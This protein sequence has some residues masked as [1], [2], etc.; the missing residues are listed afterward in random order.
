[1]SNSGSSLHV[2]IAG[3]SGLI[4][5]AL[6]PALER[7]GHRLTRLVR[8]EPRPDRD[9]LGWNPETG[10]IAA[11]AL[12]DADAV[13][14]FGGVNIASGR[15]TAKLKAAIRDSRLGSTQ[16]L[17]ETLARLT[18]PPR[19]FICASAT[20]YY[21][22]RVDEILA[23]DSPPGEGLLATLC[24]D[25]EAATSP[26]RQ[27][28]IRVVN[29]RTGVVLTPRGGALA[30]MLPAFKAGLGGVLGSGKQYVS[31]ISLH[32]LTRV[33]EFALAN[34]SITG[35]INAVAPNPV[36]NRELT[37]TLGRVLKRPTWFRMPAL[38]VRIAFGE[39]GQALLLEGHRLRPLRLEQ[40]GF[41][42]DHPTLEDALRHELE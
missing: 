30:K 9:E 37:R 41:E 3:A 10:E 31:W 36:T 20:G 8:R 15:W 32:D 6:T 2:V 1:M 24:R 5:S 11:E 40:A 38:A 14:H 4:G 18:R 42:F 22:N 21:G 7:Q 25:W 23:E 13:I 35:P 26:A 29:L 17:S 28:G 12:E 19:V 33:I 16:L 27:A 39:M 34:E